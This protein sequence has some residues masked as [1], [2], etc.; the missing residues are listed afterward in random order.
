MINDPFESS[1]KQIR[2]A[3]SLLNLK[4]NDLNRILEPQRIIRVNF[5]VKMDSF[6]AGVLIAGIYQQGKLSS[7]FAL[8]GPVGIILLGMILG[9]TG[10]AAQVPS[11]HVLWTPDV[12]HYLTMLASARLLCFIAKPAVAA[13]WGLRMSPLRWLGLISYEWYL[14]HQAPH[15]WLRFLMGSA[16]GNLPKYLTIT[17][18]PLFGSLILAALVYW[19]FS[20]PMLRKHRS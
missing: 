3:G 11:L 2:R 8:L 17:M 14:F 6:A 19:T 1:V 5:P 16:D 20:L 4:E 15:V 12:V 13:R 18:V 10:V 7:R 9:L